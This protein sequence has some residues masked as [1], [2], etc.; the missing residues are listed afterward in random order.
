MIVFRLTLKDRLAEVPAGASFLLWAALNLPDLLR[1]R[2]NP[3]RQRRLPS[4]DAIAGC[5]QRHGTVLR[6]LVPPSRA[7]LNAFLPR[8]TTPA[9]FHA[10]EVPRTCPS[11][12]Q[13]VGIGV[14]GRQGQRRPSK[15]QIYAKR[16]HRSKQ[17]A[18]SCRVEVHK[19]APASARVRN[20]VASKERL[21]GTALTVMVG[22]M[23]LPNPLPAGRRGKKQS[24]SGPESPPIKSMEKPASGPSILPQ[25]RPVQTY[26]RTTHVLDGRDAQTCRVRASAIATE[27]SVWLRVAAPCAGAPDLQP[28]TRG[29]DRIGSA[30]GWE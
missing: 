8:G 24:F 23:S 13:I 10:E 19:H 26:H 4:N 3:T 21:N 17:N 28:V 25:L 20:F 2:P 27:S 12:R 15:F 14:E 6:P 9:P 22:L 29:V 11:S 7:L 16:E 30:S 18:A 1:S 5:L